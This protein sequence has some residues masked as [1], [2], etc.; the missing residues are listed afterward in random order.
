MTNSKVIGLTRLEIKPESTAPQADALTLRHLSC[1]K[2]TNKAQRS[3]VVTDLSWRVRFTT[4]ADNNSCILRVVVDDDYEKR[5]V[6]SHSLSIV[7]DF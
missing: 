3:R 6:S 7:V 5:M 4:E 1:K 2:S